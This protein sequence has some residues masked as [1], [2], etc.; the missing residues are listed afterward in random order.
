MDTY[1]D[2]DF[3]YE[4]NITYKG[5]TLMYVKQ[6]DCPACMAFN[7]IF[8]RVANSKQNLGLP[9]SLHF[10]TAIYSPVIKQKCS[11][12]T[13]REISHTPMLIMFYNTM[14]IAKYSGSPITEQIIVSFLAS[15]FKNIL[16]VDLYPS[17]PT[18]VQQ[19]Q[20]QSNFTNPQMA[21]QSRPHF[22]SIKPVGGMYT[23]ELK[24]YFD[25]PQFGSQPPIHAPITWRTPHV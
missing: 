12:S 18:P 19:V 21:F 4:F 5:P 16:N 20:F 24:N 3:T 1:R 15:V 7:P 6:V 13:V 2:N 14:P 9:D 10:A 22:A 8:A 17:Q 25:Q 11:R 23:E